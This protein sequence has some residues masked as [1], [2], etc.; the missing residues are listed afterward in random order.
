MEAVASPFKKN[1][2]REWLRAPVSEHAAAVQMEVPFHDVDI[3]EVA[4]HGHYFR[5]F[6]IARTA[7]FRKH[8]IDVSHMR[9]LN[10]I[11][12]V[13]ESEARHIH[14]LHYG[15]AFSVAAWFTQCSPKIEVAYE[16]RNLTRQ[17]KVARARTTMVTAKH[18]GEMF[19]ETPPSILERLLSA[20]PS[21]PLER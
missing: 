17:T 7:L 14:P 20:D 4:W 16:V 1:R 12:L 3:L 10:Y 6:E 11:F 21:R 9:D 19:L 5:Y 18:Q 15:D 13:V 2:G 8:Q